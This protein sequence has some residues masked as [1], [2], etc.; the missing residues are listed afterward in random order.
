MID[1]ND[2][3]R[4][5]IAASLNL[6]IVPELPTFDLSQRPIPLLRYYAG[7][8]GLDKEATEKKIETLMKTFDIWDA[9][10]KKLRAYSQGMKK[11]FAIVAALI[12]DPKN[13]LFDETLNGL[14]PEGVR[15]MRML[16]LDL[17]KQGKSV[18][19]SSHIL[20]ELEN[21][22]DRVLIIKKGSII[23]TLDRSE[24]PSL[25]S[26]SVH[27]VVSNPDSRI[28]SVLQEYGEVQQTGHEL[29]I[30]NLTVPYEKAGLLNG[31]LAKAGYIVTKFGI[32]GEGLEEYFL[33]L[34][35]ASNA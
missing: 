30:T 20:S 1:G 29:V 27:I 11:R 19:L 9:R 25:G 2:I 16:M 15:S 12:S 24:L 7:L 5:K 34:V 32:T 22:A 33:S 17:K 14:D 18:F 13:I 31:D 23:K 8:Y 6:A 10:G 28:V 3:V 4:Q 21:I 35:G 26:P